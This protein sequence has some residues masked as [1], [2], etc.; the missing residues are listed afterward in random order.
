MR[1]GSADSRSLV[2]FFSSL[3]LVS[4]IP[5]S[6][7]LSHPGCA[8]AIA[9]QRK[10]QRLSAPNSENPRELPAPTSEKE[11]LK[12][13]K[14]LQGFQAHF[15]EEKH[16]ALLKAPLKSS[17]ELF[18]LKPGRLARKVEEPESS[19]VRVNDSVV[20]IVDQEG[21]RRID[22][23]SRPGV[24][25]FVESFSHVLDGNHNALNQY[26]LLSYQREGSGNRWSLT[27]RPRKAPLNQLIK[28][29]EIAGKGLSVS[30]LTVLEA[31]GDRTITHLSE[32]N[33]QRSFS[34][35]EKKQIF[36]IVP[37]SDGDSP[38]KPH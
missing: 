30:R 37:T 8:E 11:L 13:L 2:L 18:Y 3:S 28:T 29:I 14:Q 4:L 17:G 23:R 36:G 19:L 34:D 10:S 26:Y 9:I 1:I 35:R 20:T 7:A 21:K 22:L 5:T 27:L 33:A 16:L 38:S 6:N 15:I 32:V 12:A 31:N 24:A 25:A